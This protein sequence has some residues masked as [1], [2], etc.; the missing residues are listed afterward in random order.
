MPGKNPETLLKSVRGTIDK[1]GMLAG[2]ELV[3]VAVSGGSDS[4]ALLHSLYA[5]RKHYKI[6]LHA[7]HLE[8]G[9]RGGA[10]VEDMRFVESLCGGLG[11]PFTS[12]RIDVAKRAKASALSLEAVARQARYSFLE[13]VR[14]R[15]GA[16]KI[17]TG[18]TANDQAET[19]LLNL[20]R[21]SGVLG[22]RG[23]RPVIDGRII[24]P[25]LAAT[26]PEILAYLEKNNLKFRTDDSNLDTTYDRNRVRHVLI[27]LIEK[28]FNPRIVESLARTRELFALVAGYLQGA[29]EAEAESCRQ[30]GEGT[31]TIDLKRFAGLP[32]AVRMFTLY[33]AVRALEGDDQVATYERLSALD[34]AAGAESGTRIDI[35]SGLSAVK[36]FGALTIGRSLTATERYEVPLEIPGVTRVDPAR[37]NIEVSVI[38]EPS[39]P[40]P[41]RGTGGA[42]SECF[43]LG[44]IEPPLIARSWRAGDRLTPFGMSGSKKVQDVFVDEKIPL[45]ERGR[46][47]IIV[48]RS[49]IIWIAGVK[50]A[51][52]APVTGATS[53]A[54]RI[55]L[56]KDGRSS[57]TS[58]RRDSH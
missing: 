48:D 52:R 44:Q 49:G 53:R 41:G 24:R 21:G 51:E 50:R 11:I 3:V 5:L 9:L 25:L 17:A 26:R 33:S 36:E 13:E 28:E 38:E 20:I 30:F 6:S 2:G 14:R 37:C 55:T 47:P 15:T 1:F 10:A 29:A 35:G 42:P 45:G 56:R 43:D 8:H 31:V 7:A 40:E 57:E 39:S 34:A 58:H 22:L 12:G 16:A 4:V 27:P 19:L 32:P 23:I 18:H 46:I 54:V